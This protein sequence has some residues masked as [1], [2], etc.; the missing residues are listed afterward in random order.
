MTR[1]RDGRQKKGM[2]R[3]STLDTY[4]KMFLRYYEKANEDPMSPE[5]GRRMRKV[6]LQSPHIISLANIMV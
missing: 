4:W 1:G 6:R 3:A 5:L 2:K